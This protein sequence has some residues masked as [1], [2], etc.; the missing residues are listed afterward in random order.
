MERIKKEMLQA[1]EYKLGDISSACKIAGI[2]RAIHYNW[3]EEDKA[4]REAVNSVEKDI[5][6]L[7]DTPLG[8]KKPYRKHKLRKDC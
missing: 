4:Y 2:S 8:K 1:L 7:R 5:L 3:L 6:E